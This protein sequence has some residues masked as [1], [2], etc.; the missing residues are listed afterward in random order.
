MFFRPSRKPPLQL[1]FT[2]QLGKIGR[3]LQL[4]LFGALVLQVQVGF[5]AVEIRVGAYIVP[6]R[7][8][9]HFSVPSVVAFLAIH[10]HV[11]GPHRRRL[12]KHYVIALKKIARPRDVGND[13]IRVLALV[14]LNLLDAVQD[15]QAV[16]FVFLF[17]F[18]RRTPPLVFKVQ[19]ECGHDDKR[20]EEREVHDF[21]VVF[22]FRVFACLQRGQ[23][24]G[25]NVGLG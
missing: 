15:V 25:A 3:H 9:A 1:F 10:D 6:A 2:T 19:N 14:D 17:L 24:K 13:E 7:S 18:S 4:D 8:R 5:S 23:A 22:Q 12:A 11:H 21:R 16:H 20:C